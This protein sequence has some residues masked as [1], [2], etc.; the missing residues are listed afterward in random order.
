M[1]VVLVR[2]NEGPDDDRVVSHLVQRGLTPDIRRPF[3]GD[4]LGDI[5]DDIAATVIYGGGYNAYDIDRHPFLKEEYRWIDA[6]MSAG[7]PMLGLCQG[8]QMIA[9]HMGAWVGARGDDMHEFGYYPIQSTL[10][11]RDIFP[12]NMTVAQY[13][14]HTFDLPDGAVH[15]A[16]SEL[17]ENQAFQVGSHVFGFQFHPEQTIEG[18]RR[19][20]RWPHAPYGRPGTQSV[21]E[22]TRLMHAH[23]GT[24][25][26]W[27][28]GFL[29]QF[30]KTPDHIAKT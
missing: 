19:W 23:D 7:L 18:F 1:R 16:K 30:L 14:F 26:D 3:A 2:H 25:A 12:Q 13:H 6:A 17:F 21:D 22:Q 27:F 5:E 4:T 24:Q 8:A 10:R 29:D 20:Q 11:G 9:H 28:Y 15:L